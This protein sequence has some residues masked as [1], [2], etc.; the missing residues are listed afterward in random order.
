MKDGEVEVKKFDPV[1]FQEM[2]TEARE[3]A[4]PMAYDH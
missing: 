2:L 4:I 3:T 1:E